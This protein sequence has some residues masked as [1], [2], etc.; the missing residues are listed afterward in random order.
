MKIVMNNVQ[1]GGSSEID[2]SGVKYDKLAPAGLFDPKRL[3]DAASD[4]L[5]KT[6]AH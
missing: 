6:A 3:P 2:V 1:S 5:W 4:S